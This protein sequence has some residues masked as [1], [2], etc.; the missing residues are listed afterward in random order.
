MTEQNDEKALVSS[1]SDLL[2]AISE[3]KTP[4]E[5]AGTAVSRAA[6]I[7]RCKGCAVL[8]AER[9]GSSIMVSSDPGGDRPIVP[10]GADSQLMRHLEATDTAINSADLDKAPHPALA[11]VRPGI[12]SVLCMPVIAGGSVRGFIYLEA[13]ERG[14]FTDDTAA[15]IG[16][17]AGLLAL[18]LDAAS[19]SDRVKALTVRDEVTGLLNRDRYEEEAEVEITCAERYGRPLSLLLVGPDS[20]GDCVGGPDI[21]MKRL[22]DFLASNIRVCDRLY[23]YGED[24]FAVML[25][26]I[27]QER[28]VFTGRR[29]HVLMKRSP[30]WD[31]TSGTITASF[32]AASFPSDSVFKGGL[33]KAAEAALRLARE[34]GG[35][36]VTA[37]RRRTATDASGKSGG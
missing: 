25:P 12:H 9:D 23:R 26:G 28:A 1:L 21:V 33:G 31:A 37:Y 18:Y 35:D 14:A 4:V 29:L 34:E 19:L 15:A 22:G 3:R 8:L 20:L 6:A 30:I 5:V 13:E 2:R 7:V 24:S 16:L 27:D 10:T 11:H 32:G 17:F 36:R